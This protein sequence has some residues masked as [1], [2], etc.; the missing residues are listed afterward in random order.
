MAI[1][2]NPIVTVTQMGFN[3]QTKLV[4]YYGL[5]NADCYFDNFKVIVKPMC[6]YL[7][8]FSLCQK[9]ATALVCVGIIGFCSQ[10]IAGTTSNVSVTEGNSVTVTYNL[11]LQ[12]HLVE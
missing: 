10:I 8:K 5:G 1:V 3:N 9:L 4:V 11:D 12:P 6:R 7:L 2:V